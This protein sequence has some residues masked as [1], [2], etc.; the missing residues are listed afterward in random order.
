MKDQIFNQIALSLGDVNVANPIG[1]NESASSYSVG[2]LLTNTMLVIV[3]PFAFLISIILIAIGGL[4]IIISQGNPNAVSGGKSMIINS[5]IGLIIISIAWS[6]TAFVSTNI[7]N[8]ESV[9]KY[10]EYVPPDDGF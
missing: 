9:S 4:R 8:I 10:E 1:Y 6:A 2:T 7:L 5:I 3:F